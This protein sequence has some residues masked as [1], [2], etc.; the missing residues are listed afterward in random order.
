[1]KRHKKLENI[2]ISN[3]SHIGLTYSSK[4]NSEIT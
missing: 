3:K 4:I 1:M 2:I